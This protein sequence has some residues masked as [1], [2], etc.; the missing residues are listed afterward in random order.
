MIFEFT[1]AR[2]AEDCDKPKHS[3]HR[4]FG[5]MH[6]LWLIDGAEDIDRPLMDVRGDA[7]DAIGGESMLTHSQKQ[8]ISRRMGMATAGMVLERYFE[9]C[10]ALAET[11]GQPCGIGIG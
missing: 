9:H 3:T 8:R 5:L 2:A 1:Q 11:I 7:L 10:P 4:E 6:C